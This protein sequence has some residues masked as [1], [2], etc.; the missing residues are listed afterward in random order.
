MS[1]PSRVEAAASLRGLE[2]TERL[3]AHS[4]A[5]AEVCSFLCAK[6]QDRGVV[7]STSL[8][9]AAA[10]LHDLDKALPPDDPLR[11]MGHG[12]AGAEWVRR[13]GHAELAEA[14]AHHPVTTLADP[15]GYA[16]WAEE[17]GLEGRVVAYADKRALQDVV[18]LDQ[19]FERWYRRH[20]ASPLMALAHERAQRLEQEICAAAGIDPGDVRR[21]A[22]VDDALSAAAA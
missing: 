15:R 6:L 8:G 9:E 17:A 4:A 16:A 20:S 14:I 13:H 5:V 19:R 10:L 3:L 11:S 1:I 12:A 21:L 7:V 2:P 22:W 18:P